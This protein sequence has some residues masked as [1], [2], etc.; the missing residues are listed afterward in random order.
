MKPR[1]SG[2]PS[3][4]APGSAQVRGCCAGVASLPA[5]SRFGGRLPAVSQRCG[6]GAPGRRAR[7]GC[8]GQ[9]HGRAG[10]AAGR[11]GRWWRRT[12]RPCLRR[13]TA[14][15]LS[16][17]WG[18]GHGHGHGQFRLLFSN[19]GLGCTGSPAEPWSRSARSYW[20]RACTRSVFLFIRSLSFITIPPLPLLQVVLCKVRPFQ[21]QY[22]GRRTGHTQRPALPRRRL[23][24]PV[25]GS[26]GAFARLEALRVCEKLA[27]IL[28]SFV[29]SSPQVTQ[30][31]PPNNAPERPLRVRTPS[32]FPGPCTPCAGCFPTVC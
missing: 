15:C 25:W 31:S 18:G 20:E 6:R 19:A 9:P 5:A 2:G 8:E 26:V 13:L 16:H 24:R 7:C 27:Y 21:T 11:V 17:G 4:G 28:L 23:N 1:P 3:P 32:S 30:C 22:R 29:L 12:G 14:G 10:S